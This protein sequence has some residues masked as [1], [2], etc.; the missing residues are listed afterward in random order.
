M[1]WLTGGSGSGSGALSG[2][3]SWPPPSPLR[4]PGT[5][6]LSGFCLLRP[7]FSRTLVRSRS[8]LA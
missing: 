2:T 7:R 1:G 4:S 3:P 8:S 6:S 5:R